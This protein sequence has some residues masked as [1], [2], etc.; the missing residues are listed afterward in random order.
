[1]VGTIAPTDFGWYTFLQEQQA[2]KEVN[3][4]RPSAFRSWKVEHFSPFLFK[5]KAPHN[6]I[7]GFG[8]FSGYSAIPTW[9]AWEAFGTANGCLSRTSMDQRI[10]TIRDRMNFRGDA[11]A[12]FIGSILIVTPTFFSREQ[13][14]PQPA[15]WPKKNLGPM[16]YDL[17]VREGK[18]VWQACLER[19]TQPSLTNNDEQTGFS[20]ERYG[21][22]RQIV[23][24]LGQGTFRI[25]VTD[26]YARACAI[27]NE[28]SLPALEAAHIRP[29][30]EAGPHEIQNG[31]LL[32]ADFHRLFDQ[33]YLTIAPSLHVEVSRRLKED[34]E[35]G[36]SYYPYH[37]KTIYLPKSPLL[38]P[39]ASFLTWHNEHRYRG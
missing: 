27:T 34:Y 30:S 7:C 17:S 9:L 31:L 19:T 33:G 2:L 36:R 28:H 22:A 5:L 24:R 32:R 10:Q 1:M 14:I 20:K 38:T 4:W 29:Y 23:P 12:D 3:F 39:S 25:S 37:G 15:D 18:R 13:W 8:F 26:A 35:N 16:K 21:P 11:P 6:A